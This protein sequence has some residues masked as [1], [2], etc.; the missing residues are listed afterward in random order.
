MNIAT[1]SWVHEV[2]M[3]SNS[4]MFISLYIFFVQNFNWFSKDKLLLP[5]M[6]IL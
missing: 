1:L 5:Q 2:Y 3:E 4:I 6:Q